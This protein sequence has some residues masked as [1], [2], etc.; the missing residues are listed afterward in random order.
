MNKLSVIKTP[1]MPV[2]NENFV[3]NYYSSNEETIDDRKLVVFE[4]EEEYYAIRTNN[5]NNI[6]VP[7][8]V[9]FSIDVSSVNSYNFNSV[10]FV[11]SNILEKP[12][13]NEII[14]TVSRLGEK[15]DTLEE[16]YDNLFL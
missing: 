10:D 3:Y 7:R 15:L 6:V 14:D 13:I 1:Q 8:Y 4:G 5:A 2:F 9:T 11:N 12:S 16:S